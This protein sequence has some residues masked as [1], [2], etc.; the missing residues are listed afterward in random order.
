MKITGSRWLSLYDLNG[1]LLVKVRKGHGR[2]YP[3]KLNISWRCMVATEGPDETWMWHKRYGHL[4][5]QS[6]K[7]ISTHHLA[8]GFPLIGSPETLCQECLAGKQTRTTYPPATSFRASQHLELVHAY[9]C[10][11]I[12]PATLG[13]SCYFLLIVDDF[14]RLMWISMLKQKSETFSAFQILNYWLKLR[15]G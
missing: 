3:V 12:T 5:F 11:P 14:F 1:K 6:L 7:N 8:E 13:G 2:L 4:N 10:G 9:I 15:R